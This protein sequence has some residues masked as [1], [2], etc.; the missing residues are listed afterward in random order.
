MKKFIQKAFG[1]D[2]K[3]SSIKTEIL[4]GLTTFL[5]MAYILAVNPGIFSALDGMPGGSVFTATALA[6]ILG[7]LVMALWAKK[8]FALAPGMGLNAFFVFT[9]CLGMGY[10]WQFALTAVLIEGLLFIILTLTN[11]RKIIVD[12][13]P[14]SIKKAIGCGIGLFIAFIGLN[15]AG[16]VVD[17]PATL[18]S[19]GDITSG[20][21]LVA[22]I[23][24][25]FTAFL[26]VKKVPGSLLI[27]MISTAVLGMFIKDPATGKHITEFSGVVSMP[28][29]VAP[30]FCQF[31]WSQILSLDM[32][33]V[34]F[35]FMFID[36][37]DTIGTVVGV[38]TKAGMVDEKGN[39]PGL[40]RI[41]LADAIATVGGACFG[42]STTTTYVESAS[43]IAQG[44]RSGL[45][46]FIT[47]LCFAVALFFSPIFLAIPGAA[48]APVLIIV[49][50][51]M[52]TPIKD[53]DFSNYSEAIPAFITMV[54]MPLCYSISDGIM[55]GIISY[56]LI[57]LLSCN[58]KKINPAAY[59]LAALFIAKY[60]F[61]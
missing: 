53:I 27:G 45:T 13:I 9:V 5:T 52:M 1:Y 51:F 59:I 14:V 28:E 50:V 37:F 41:L 24:L 43:G 60:I 35:T 61:L 44:G 40:N 8:P 22:F 25:I 46:A 54:A 6:S 38:S 48:T 15:N 32:V 2:P 49:G 29:S 47:A 19:I 30:I 34:V 11:I 56:V 31:E 36:M 18:V 42:T 33:I 16:I 4:A 7:T 57:N 55:L 20:K 39:I 3:T 12:S 21:A 17:N 58:F 26:V 23:G 10:S